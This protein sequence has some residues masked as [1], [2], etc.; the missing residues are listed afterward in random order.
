MRSNMKNLLTTSIYTLL[1]KIMYIQSKFCFFCSYQRHKYNPSQGEFRDVD[2]LIT[3][4]L[5]MFRVQAWA[6]RM[7]DCNCNRKTLQC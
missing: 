7:N 5:Y 6:L 3:S 1:A 2:P 4:V